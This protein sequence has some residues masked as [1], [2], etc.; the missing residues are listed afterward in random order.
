MVCDF[1]AIFFAHKHQHHL[2]IFVIFLVLFKQ[3][4]NNLLLCFF[5]SLF[6][7]GK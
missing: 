2:F 6:K 3:D 7:E 5:V 1:V 4:I